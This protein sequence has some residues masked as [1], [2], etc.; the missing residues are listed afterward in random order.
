MKSPKMFCLLCSKINTI[1]NFTIKGLKIQYE[2]EHYN[3]IFIEH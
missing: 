3:L 1:L 2:V